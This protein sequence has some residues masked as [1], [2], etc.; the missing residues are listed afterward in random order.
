MPAIR[1]Q[2][3]KYLVQLLRATMA[4]RMPG[5]NYFFHVLPLLMECDHA[6]DEMIRM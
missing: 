4:S 3:V 5:G 6:G 2:L 1:V